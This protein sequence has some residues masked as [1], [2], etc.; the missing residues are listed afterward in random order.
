VPCYLGGLWGSIFSYEGGKVFW[1][2]PKHWRYPVTIRFGRP[3]T[4]PESAEDVRHAVEE[5]A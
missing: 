5:L 4:E 3:I 2:W 1:K